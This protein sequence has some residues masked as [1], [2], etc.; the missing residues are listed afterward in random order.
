MTRATTSEVVKTIKAAG[1]PQKSLDTGIVL[2]D[3][4]G[5]LHV[6]R[7][8][9]RYTRNAYGRTDGRVAS[10]PIGELIHHNT[11]L[12]VAD[13]LAGQYRHNM[14]WELLL[15]ANTWDVKSIVPA[16]D[17]LTERFETGKGRKPAVGLVGKHHKD[18]A[19]AL[20]WIEETRGKNPGNQVKVYLDELQDE[21]V[22]SLNRLRKAAKNGSH[23]KVLLEK[24]QR[25]LVPNN[26]KGDLPIVDETTLI[27]GISPLA[28]G[29][30]QKIRE[31]LTAFTIAQNS[32]GQ[33]LELPRYVY[34]YILRSLTSGGYYQTLIQAV[35]HPGDE[36][37]ETLFGV[38]NPSDEGALRDLNKA[39]D[40]AKLL[41]S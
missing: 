32:E 10:F 20:R 11:C 40:A 28:R 27:V 12:C 26:W 23:R 19:E 37:V 7:G 35:E 3:E 33:L 36:I 22:K 5:V 29:A 1:I 30:N 16:M 34:E 15:I 14:A 41:K 18:T 25:E 31:V 21:L 39:V 8:W 2:K 17:R 9:C 13:D 6:D 24:V 4:R 38:W